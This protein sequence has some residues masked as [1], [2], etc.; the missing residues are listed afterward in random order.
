M[1]LA[2]VIKYLNSY[3]FCNVSSTQLKK[4]NYQILKIKI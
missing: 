4:K 3:Y 1:T 2:L